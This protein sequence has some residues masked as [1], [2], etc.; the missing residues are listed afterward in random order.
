L[1][2]WRSAGAPFSARFGGVC[3]RDGEGL[4]QNAGSPVLSHAVAYVL[5][6]EYN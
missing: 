1:L 4:G 3:H 6:G 2:E 5:H